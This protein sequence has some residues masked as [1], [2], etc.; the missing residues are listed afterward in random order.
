[1]SEDV[2]AKEGSA[3]SIAGALPSAAPTQLL[4]LQHTAPCSAQSHCDNK[5][6][7]EVRSAFPLQGLLLFIPPCATLSSSLQRREE[8]QFC[9]TKAGNRAINFLASLQGAGRMDAALSKFYPFQNRQ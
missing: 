6:F 2:I 8:L 1:M 5:H 4:C 7:S 3:L 9:T